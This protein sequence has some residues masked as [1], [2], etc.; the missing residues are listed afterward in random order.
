MDLFGGFGGGFEIALGDVGRDLDDVAEFAVDLDGD[1]ER[2]FDEQGG[3]ELWP[4]LVG[5]GETVLR[6]A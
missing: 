2:V 1:F 3:V 4:R 6:V 5:K